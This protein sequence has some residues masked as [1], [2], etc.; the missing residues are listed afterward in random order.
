[1]DRLK[2]YKSKR[3]LAET[4]EPKGKTITSEEE[5]NFVVQEHHA[6]HLH[7]DFRL[8]HK[9][10]LKSFAMPKTPSLNP[11]EKHLAIMV[12]DH[13]IDYQY[14][15]GVIPEGHYG[16]GKVKIWDKG[17]YSVKNADT[18]NDSEKAIQ[19]GLKN[20]LLEIVLHGKKLKGTF[21]LVKMKNFAQKDSWLFFKKQEKS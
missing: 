13:P 19:A 14:F 1:M 5:L 18:R 20:G 7:Y 17:K 8:E 2:E 6:T 12:E 10:V 21:V 4:G 16:A 15:E 3:K 11:A 9:G